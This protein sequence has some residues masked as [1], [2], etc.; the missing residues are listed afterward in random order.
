[1]ILRPLGTLK[2]VIT[3]YH[4]HL[5]FRTL[6]FLGRYDTSY[7]TYLVLIDHKLSKLKL[8]FEFKYTEQ[9]FKDYK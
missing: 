9:E 5:N 2:S 3:N 7:L 1:M 8:K 6:D 4:C